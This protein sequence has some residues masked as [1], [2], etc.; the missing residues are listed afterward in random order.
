[1]VKGGASGGFWVGGTWVPGGDDGG[2]NQVE[3]GNGVEGDRGEG[4]LAAAGDDVVEVDSG[5]DE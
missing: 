3:V 1:M 5:T 4:K 2:R